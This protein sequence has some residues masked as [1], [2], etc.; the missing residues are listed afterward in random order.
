[1][2]FLLKQIFN[3][4]KLLNSDTATRQIA[5]GVS[6]GLILGFAPAFSLQTILVI[7]ALFFLRIQIGAA[8]LSAFF[9]AFAAWLLDPLSNWIGVAVL[10]SDSLHPIFIQ[11]YNLPIV[12]FTRFYNSLV[13]GSG[14]VSIL[15][16]APIYF[17]SIFL[18]NKYRI[19]IVER[20]KGSKFWKAVKATTFYKWYAKYEELYS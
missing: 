6:C 12:P 20:F 13:M 18:I 5:A 2:T 9:F 3:L 4:V 16:A 19:G 17:L 10:E 14:L 15:L 8:T 1:M 7:I 11:M